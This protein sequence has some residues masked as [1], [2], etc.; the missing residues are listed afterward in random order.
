MSHLTIRGREPETPLA[1]AILVAAEALDIWECF[2]LDDRYH[3]ALGGGWTVAL[4]ADSADR[5]RVESCRLTRPVNMMW[6][7]SHRS[8]RL[9][10]LVRKMSTV[11]EAV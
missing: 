11:P 4:C 6:T 1:D 5:I 3:F 2:A 7:L 8:D 10:G 9:A